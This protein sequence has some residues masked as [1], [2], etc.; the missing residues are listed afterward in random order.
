MMNFLMIICL[1]AGLS[2]MVYAM[3][4]NIIKHFTNNKTNTAIALLYVVMT[5]SFF[6]VMLIAFCFRTILIDIT[7]I[8]YR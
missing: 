2:L 5:V 1:L 6:I 8:F 7:N 4:Q 3:N